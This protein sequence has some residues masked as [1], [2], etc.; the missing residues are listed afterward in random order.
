MKQINEHFEVLH[1][2]LCKDPIL[3]NTVTNVKPFQKL[4][5]RVFPPLPICKKNYKF[6]KNFFFI[7]MIL[8]ILSRFNLRKVLLK[9]NTVL[10][11]N[12]VGKNSSP[13]RIRLKPDAKL[14]PQRPIQGP[15]LYRDILNNLL[16]HP[17]ENGKLKQTGSMIYEKP[18]L[19]LLF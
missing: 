15:L 1:F 12:D 17:Q 7:T 5:P 16:D 19:E 14:L 4:A 6:S 8:L 18:N 10:H 11:R 2:E 9:R 3:N 13:F